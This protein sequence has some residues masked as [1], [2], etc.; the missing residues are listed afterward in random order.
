MGDVVTSEKSRERAATSWDSSLVHRRNHLGKRKIRLFAD[1]VK[2]LLG[3][4]LQLRN[5]S[6]AIHGLRSSVFAK[7]SHPPDRGADADF[8]PLR[9]FMP[10]CSFF[11]SANDAHSQLTGIW[12]AH[13]LTLRRINALDSLLRANLGIPIHS[14]RDALD[15][16]FHESCHIAAIHL[17]FQAPICRA[18]A[19]TRRERYGSVA[20]GD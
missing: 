7:T 17:W 4:L 9:R 16:R 1:E 18:E 8:E 11:H 3:I 20:S 14:D 15:D 13:W 5:A 19:E 6:P 2:N 12:S 10:G